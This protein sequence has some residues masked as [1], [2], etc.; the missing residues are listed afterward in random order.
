MNHCLLMVLIISALRN[1]R[2]QR[3]LSDDVIRP[4]RSAFLCYVSI[5][6]QYK[7]TLLPG[8]LQ[9]RFIIMS[10]SKLIFLLVQVYMILVY[11][12]IIIL[13]YC[14][15]LNSTILFLKKNAPQIHYKD[16]AKV[17]IDQALTQHYGSTSVLDFRANNKIK[18]S[19]L[20]K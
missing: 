15:D 14:I 19:K 7:H 11:G 10:F 9:V 3:W 4:I 13:C 18:I 17:H 20:H 6:N 12:F 2:R 5:F 16:L 1:E 8:L